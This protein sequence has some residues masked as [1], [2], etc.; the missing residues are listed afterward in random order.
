[1]E[2]LVDGGWFPVNSKHVAPFVSNH[3]FAWKVKRRVMAVLKNSRNRIYA[4]SFHD[5]K[6]SL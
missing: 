3:H 6:K 1:M 5:L 4:H 2:E